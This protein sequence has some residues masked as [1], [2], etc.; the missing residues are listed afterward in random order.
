MTLSVLVGQIRTTCTS[1]RIYLRANAL[2]QQ[3]CWLVLVGDHRGLAGTLL[4]RDL[5]R[6]LGDTEGVPLGECSR[7][8]PLS[9]L[10]FFITRRERHSHEGFSRRIGQ[11]TLSFILL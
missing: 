2:L 9:A 3:Q 5:H 6:L 7:S 1:Q 8:P 11:D 10:N 4:H